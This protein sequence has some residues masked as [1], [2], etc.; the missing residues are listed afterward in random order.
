MVPDSG[1]RRVRLPSVDVILHC[2]PLEEDTEEP[3]QRR[4]A[5]AAAAAAT[6]GTA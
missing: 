3:T 5:A 1:D 4:P 2:A 6:V